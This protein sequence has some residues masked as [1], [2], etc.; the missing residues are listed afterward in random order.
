MSY[1]PRMF[2]PNPGAPMPG[3]VHA[4][5]QP[6]HPRGDMPEQVA[7][8]DPMAFQS[9]IEYENARQAQLAYQREIAWRQQTGQMTSRSK[10]PVRTPTIQPGLNPEVNP[11]VAK[12][13]PKN[14]RP[15]PTHKPARYKLVDRRRPNFA[16]ANTGLFIR[17]ILKATMSGL[18]FS[19]ILFFGSSS[20]T[21][22][23]LVAG[24]VISVACWSAVFYRA[25]MLDINS[26]SAAGGGPIWIG[27]LFCSLASLVLY[28]LDK[29]SFDV[30]YPAL[31]G[32]F[33]AWLMSTQFGSPSDI[34]TDILM[35]RRTRYFFR[36]SP[37]GHDCQLC[38]SPAVAA[39]AMRRYHFK[40]PNNWRYYLPVCSRHEHY[41]CEIN[42]WGMQKWPQSADCLQPELLKVTPKQFRH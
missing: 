42:E 20:Y 10:G 19:C 12:A 7:G 32:T 33:L 15:K 36:H 39:T 30:E 21:L 13:A 5:N 1:D 38:K 31:V 28:L 18:A 35:M 24:I 25:A 4:W 27:V 29:N 6:M 40:D 22:R 3:E 17:L 34:S 26:D 9:R 2:E 41:V 23:L 37:K 8:L 14:E 16:L 11:T